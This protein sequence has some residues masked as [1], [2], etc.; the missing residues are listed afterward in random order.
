[1]RDILIYNHALINIYSC[2]VITAVIESLVPM[3]NQCTC[4][5]ID[6]VI[7]TSISFA[8]WQI[9]WKEYID[10]PIETEIPVV[11]FDSTAE[12][13]DIMNKDVVFWEFKFCFKLVSGI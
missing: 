12:N 10:V 6:R 8:L 5:L 9:S 13:L 4:I 3:L 2:T 7:W 11:A 1:M